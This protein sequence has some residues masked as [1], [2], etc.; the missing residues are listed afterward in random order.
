[1]LKKAQNHALLAAWRY[2]ALKGVIKWFVGIAMHSF[3]INVGSKSQDMTIIKL[4][5]S[6]SYLTKPR[7]C[8]GNVGGK[9]K[10][11]PMLLLH[12]EMIIYL[13]LEVIMI[14]ERMSSILIEELGG[15][16]I[17]AVVAA[18]GLLRLIVTALRVDSPIIGLQITI[19]C[20]VGAVD[21]I[22]VQ[23]VERCCRGEAVECILGR[24]VVLNIHEGIP[25]GLV[26]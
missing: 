17:E 15:V 3:A 23:C 16:G 13:N 26:V 14:K 19:I 24:R 2:N 4:E 7:S 22:S 18:A 21:C 1:L 25:D 20:I 10:Q 8:D 5:A 6:V 11:V 12:L 9:N